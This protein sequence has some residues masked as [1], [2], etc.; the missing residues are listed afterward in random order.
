MEDVNNVVNVDQWMRWFAIHNL[1]GN[2]ET[3]LGNGRG[4]DYRFFMGMNDKRA[5]LVVHDLDTVLGLGDSPNGTTDSIFRAADP[6]HLPIIERFLEHPDFV[7]RYYAVLK[8]LTET[9]F[10]PEQM[11][12]LVNQTLGGFVPQ[13]TINAIK[14]F[15]VDRVA[16]VLT[17]IPLELTAT[18][19]LSVSG[20]FYHTTTNSG[21]VSGYANAINTR[22]VTVNGLEAVWTAFGA[23]Y[24]FDIST[25]GLTLNPGVNRLVVQSFDGDGDELANVVAA[26][27]R[28]LAV[29]CCLSLCQ[30]HEH[31]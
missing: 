29:D 23:Q 31:R 5:V 25:S 18:S 1:I 3:N 8:E 12:P 10:S 17:Q 24:S 13:L 11:D 15:V 22:S 26:V 28:K 9:T 19:S 21:V 7:P 6:V 16:N 14:Q 2:N 4:D 20:D 27:I 30:G